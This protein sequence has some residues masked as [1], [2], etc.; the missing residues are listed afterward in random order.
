MAFVYET[1]RKLDFNKNYEENELGPGQYLPISSEKEIK[2]NIIPFLSSEQKL[3]YKE[4]KNPG[5]GT[6]YRDITKEEELKRKENKKMEIINKIDEIKTSNKILSPDDPETK[7]EYQAE[8]RIKKNYEK[9]GFSVKEKRFKTNENFIPGPGSF[10]NN[11]YEEEEKK[12]YEKIKNDKNKIIQYEKKNKFKIENSQFNID[13]IPQKNSFGYEKNSEGK[14]VKKDNPQKYKIFSGIEGIDTIGPGTYDIDLPEY[15]KK[16]GTFWSK[17]KGIRSFQN[18]EKIRPKTSLNVNHINCTQGNF[19]EENKNE[20]NNLNYNENNNSY[21]GKNMNFFMNKSIYKNYNSGFNKIGD[22]NII[23]KKDFSF[24]NKNNNPGPGTY[25]LKENNCN[26]GFF[27][28]AKIP[29]KTPFNENNYFFSSCDRF[30]NGINS[31]IENNIKSIEFNDYLF[32]TNLKKIPIRKLK[33]EIKNSEEKNKIKKTKKSKNQKTEKNKKNEKNEKNEKND[34]PKIAFLSQ[35]TRFPKSKSLTSE[36]NEREIPK[37]KYV[38]KTIFSNKLLNSSFSTSQSSYNSRP[39]TGNGTFYRRDRR[40]REAENELIR[41]SENPGPG[42]YIDPFSN[43]GI[44]NTIIING[45]FVDLRTGNNIINENK[46][47]KSS[48]SDFFKNERNQYINFNNNPGVGKYD[49]GNYNSI[50]YLNDKF[51]VDRINY[52]KN[53]ILGFDSSEKDKRCLKGKK[54][55]L[56]PGS[57][58]NENYV[59]EFQIDPPF[60]SSCQ[61]SILD[62]KLKKNQLDGK[63]VGPGQYDVEECYPWVKQSFNIKYL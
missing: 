15:W 2:E 7:K 28:A 46:R 57:Y 55:K 10:F 26:S 62:K 48:K 8:K 42:S 37:K 20:K 31:P 9:Y 22:F 5:P 58:Y 27:N 6:Y 59:K 49:N 12:T 50:K 32:G 52:N 13:S 47:P 60:N 17:N 61:R 23:N 63:F 44:N 30:G 51:Y 36:K 39:L 34:K 54:E 45:R 25:F 4:N 29:K 43:T 38:H 35:S 11:K 33:N 24:V 3:K 21:N 19:R 18:K 41:L 14:I 16:K 56:G 53:N 40:F 1:E